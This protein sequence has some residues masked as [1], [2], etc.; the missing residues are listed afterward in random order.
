MKKIEEAL[1]KDY[2]N[3]SD[4]LN[5]EDNTNIEHYKA[6]L[7]ER[8]KIRNEIIK[9]KQI[10]SERNINSNKIESENKRDKIR[11]RITIITT[12]TNILLSIYC[13]N[14]T[15]KFDQVSTVTSTLGRNILN[16]FVPKLPKK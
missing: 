16:G 8:D 13:I 9:I 10:D 14:R 3:I 5:V 2:K 12:V 11:N 7:E 4:Q 15:F 6:A 1:W